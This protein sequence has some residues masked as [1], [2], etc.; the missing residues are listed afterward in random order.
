M[1]QIVR[2]PVPD[3]LAVGSLAWDVAS[4]CVVHRLMPRVVVS[5]GRQLVPYVCKRRLIVAGRWCRLHDLVYEKM[6]MPL[7]NTHGVFAHIIRDKTV[8]PYVYYVLPLA[9]IAE[10][11]HKTSWQ[12]VE[13][14]PHAHRWQKYKDAWHLLC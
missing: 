6:R 4:E 9:R 11:L 13:I 3:G 10:E 8:Q 7:S 1:D 5:P 12:R 14:D 2:I